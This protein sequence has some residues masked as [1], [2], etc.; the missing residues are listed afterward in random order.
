MLIGKVGLN[1]IANDVQTQGYGAAHK[2][3]KEANENLSVSNFGDETKAGSS[4]FQKANEEAN[5]QGQKVVGEKMQ[6]STQTREDFATKMSYQKNATLAA[7]KTN[8]LDISQ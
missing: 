1:S 6:D 2:A 4:Q 3:S 7:I 8:T 5:A